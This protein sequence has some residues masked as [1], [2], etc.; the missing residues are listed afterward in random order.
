[1]K[2]MT[3]YESFMAQVNDPLFQEDYAYLRQL[4][5]DVKV[6]AATAFAELTGKDV[7]GMVGVTAT[8]HGESL[9]DMYDHAP[10][11]AYFSTKSSR[12]VVLPNFADLS[13]I[14]DA[15]YR[16][17]SDLKAEYE[18]ADDHD[19]LFIPSRI[20]VIGPDGE[21]LAL[22]VKGQWLTPSIPQEEWA[23]TE[24]EI[25]ALNVE[26]ANEARWDNFATASRLRDQATLLSLKLGLC[27]QH[28]VSINAS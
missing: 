19:G 20:N 25:H 1:M 13:E 6:L 24:T 8:I 26:A 15:A 3:D 9:C 23:R 21:V 14:R 2:T 27:L 7:I 17:F 10:G 4:K 16:E 12:G 18:A 22:Y 11:M 28:D 5:H